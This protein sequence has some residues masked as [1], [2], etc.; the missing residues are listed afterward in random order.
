MSTWL[1]T[2]SRQCR[3]AE[4]LDSQLTDAYIIWEDSTIG[5]SGKVFFVGSK[6]DKYFYGMWTYDTFDKSNTLDQKFTIF[7]DITSI[8][9]W[10]RE[11][12]D[13]DYPKRADLLNVMKFFLT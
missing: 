1:E 13:S 3:G 10:L 9:A 11:M 12:K 5:E 7:E 2:A 8:K 6:S 4:K